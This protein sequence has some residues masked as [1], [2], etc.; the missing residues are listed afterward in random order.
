MD[1]LGVFHIKIIA[2]LLRFTSNQ[3]PLV[4]YCNFHSSKHISFAPVTPNRSKSLWIPNRQTA[5]DPA[6]V[7]LPDKSS[8]CPS[9]CS[10]CPLNFRPLFA[11]FALFAGTI[12]AVSLVASDA[13][14]SSSPRCSPRY[15]PLNVC[16]S[17]SA[18]LHNFRRSPSQSPDSSHFDST[19]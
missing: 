2:H 11:D 8:S 18:P 9:S 14:T 10:Q 16:S 13:C 15:C 12:A 7:Y 1:C 5:L 17:F 3:N 4:N 6:E 19:R